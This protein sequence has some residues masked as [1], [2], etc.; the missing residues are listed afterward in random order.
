MPNPMKPSQLSWLWILAILAVGVLLIFAAFAWDGVVQN[1][2]HQH[3]LKN[4]GLIRRWVT[5]ATDWPLHVILALGFAGLAWRRG[6]R[7][8]TRIFLAM[9]LAGALAGLS[10]YVLKAATGRVRPSVNVEKGWSKRTLTLQA[11]YQ[12]FPSGHTAFSAGFFA[13]LLL[14]NWRIGLFCLPIAVFVAFSR[15]FLGA[16]YLS[17][18]VAAI[19][20]GV[21]SAMLIAHL[22][23]ERDA[24]TAPPEKA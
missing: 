9:I 13:L 21:V 3:Q 11:N 1:W 6:N 8:W 2:L 12:S 18:V 10:A 19:V 15:I 23:L 24:E 17:D 4:I 16:H 5:R 20:L 7:K 14:A 22:M